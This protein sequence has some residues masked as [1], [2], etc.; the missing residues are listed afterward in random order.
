[1]S[2]TPFDLPKTIAQSSG[3]VGLDY[4]GDQQRIRKTSSGS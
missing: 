3:T 2:Y 4:D 1:V